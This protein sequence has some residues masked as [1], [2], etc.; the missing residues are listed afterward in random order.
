[1]VLSLK[2]PALVWPAQWLADAQLISYSWKDLTKFS[3]LRVNS[4]PLGGHV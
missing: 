2:T 4:W 3:E 1:M